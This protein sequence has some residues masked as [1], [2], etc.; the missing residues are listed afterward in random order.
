MQLK[1]LFGGLVVTVFSALL[2][3]YYVFG[4]ICKTDQDYIT[5]HPIRENLWEFLYGA[6]C[7]EAAVTERK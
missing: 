7:E 6:A 1:Y 5:K 3:V 2:L 4:V